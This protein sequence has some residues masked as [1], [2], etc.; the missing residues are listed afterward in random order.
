MVLRIELPPGVV[1]LEGKIA[2]S[3]NYIDCDKVRWVR[4]RPEKIGGWVRYVATA[5]V[6]IV[7][8]ML[9]WSDGTARQFLAAGTESKLYAIATTDFAPIDITPFAQSATILNPFTTTL[10]S[11][12]VA[13]AFTAHNA[14]TGDNINIAGPVTL[15]GVTLN[16]DYAVVS[17]INANAFTIAASAPASASGS[18]GGSVTIGI[19]IA[20]GAVDPAMGFGWGAGPYGAGTYGTPRDVSTVVIDIRTWSLDQFGRILLAN[21]SGG[22][23][24]S[25]DPLVDPP[26]RAAKVTGAPFYPGAMA[27]FFV[28]KERIVIA[29]GTDSSGTQDLLEVWT[30]AQGDYTNWDWTQ[31]TAPTG[32]PSTLSRFHE[33]R[34]VV[35][36]AD[37]G[38][39]VSLLWTDTA[40]YLKQYTGSKS[41]FSTRFVGRYCG[42]VGPHAFAVV[43][44]IAYW[45]SENAFWKYG[46]GLDK[47]PNSS[48]IAEWVFH[49]VRARYTVK[50]V[51]W[52]NARFSEIWFQFVVGDNTEPSIYV[53]YNYENQRW[54]HGTMARTAAAAVVGARG[55]ILAGPNGFIY[56]HEVGVDDDGAPMAWRLETAPVEMA[57]GSRWMETGPLRMDMQRQVGDI[58]VTLRAFDGTNVDTPPLGELALTVAS[59]DGQ[60]DTR[61]DGRHIAARFEGDG[62]G[63]DF[64]FGVPRIE[65]KNGGSR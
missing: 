48:D 59:H 2:A 32:A 23:L 21:P 33:G 42:L 9:G 4:G 60:T 57:D 11:T 53:V 54:F 51:A 12:A 17:V 61:L 56:E 3:G 15:N 10:G 24:Y 35:A 47:I 19:E 41:V 5:L 26:E 16:G 34:R 29:F 1:K 37:L 31:P 63:C 55:P 8:G 44:G 6:G 52:V 7:R 58:I 62:L 20:P 18:G 45:V 39:L 64:R 65:L 28:T 27:G 50:T 40:L 43:N 30:S 13:V 38:N 49:Q 36:G 22:A 25:W 14:S 46:G